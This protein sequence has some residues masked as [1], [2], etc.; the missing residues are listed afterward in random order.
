MSIIGTRP[1]L[2]SETNLYELHHKMD[3]LELRDVNV[4]ILDLYAECKYIN[5]SS[6]SLA[7]N[8]TLLAAAAILSGIAHIFESI[9]TNFINENINVFTNTMISFGSV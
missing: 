6:L 7:T 5:G 2:I 4:G 8:S 1:P 9:S 3:N